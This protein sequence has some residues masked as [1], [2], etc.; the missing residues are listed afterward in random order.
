MRRWFGALLGALL[1]MVLVAPAAAQS[2]NGQVRVVHASP[3]APAVDVFVDGTAVLE[4]VEFGDASQYLSVPAGAHTF[5]VAPAGQGVGAAVITA[6]ATIAAGQAY[7]V[8]A[9]G[10]LASIE[11][12]IFND[13]LAAPAAGKAHIRVIHL[14]PDAPAVDLKTQDNAV[15]LVSNLAYPNASDYLPV[16]AGSYDLK[17]TAAGATDA[18]LALDDVRLQAGTIY[19]FFAIGLLDNLQVLP[20]STTPSGALPGTGVSDLPFGLL[21]GVALVVL[22]SG[23]VL[24]RRLA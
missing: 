19:D 23:V 15:T 24:R 5:V 14:S 18:V 6:D 9:I 4:G 3:D 21:A 13:N 22:A 11:G 1:L 7:T 16:D 8:A 17:V 2:G 20:V 10:Q 12:K